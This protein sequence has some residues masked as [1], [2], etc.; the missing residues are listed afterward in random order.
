[1]VLAQLQR[2]LLVRAEGEGLVEDLCCDVV[3]GSLVEMY[4]CFV[5]EEN[6]CVAM[7][8]E[9]QIGAADIVEDDR[10]RAFAAE[11]L[12]GAGDVKTHLRGEGDDERSGAAMFDDAADDVFGGFEFERERAVAMQLAGGDMADAEVGDGSG[13]DDDGCF[14]QAR[15][16]GGMH[17][18][19]CV[20]ADELAARRRGER[21]GGGDED[22]AGAA[23]LGCGG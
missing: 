21:S 9:A 8:V 2:R 1:M 17:V 5:R 3:L 20:D 12:A 18:V 14:G 16:H 11:L 7:G 4:G 22:D 23:T 19:C 15:E 6:G 10:V 13:L